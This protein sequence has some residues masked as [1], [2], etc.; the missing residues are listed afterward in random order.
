MDM[1]ELVEA[2]EE[3]VTQPK[4]ELLITLTKNMCRWVFHL[5]QRVFILLEVEQA[6][7]HQKRVNLLLSILHPQVFFNNAMLLYLL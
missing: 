7:F 3:N 1:L 2:L 4:A 6:L 5:N